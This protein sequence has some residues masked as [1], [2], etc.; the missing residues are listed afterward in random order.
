MPEGRRPATGGSRARRP[1]GPVPPAD[2]ATGVPSAIK[3]GV[4][5][6]IRDAAGRL[7]LEQRSDCGQWGLPGGRVEPGESVRDAALREVQEETGLVVEITRLVGVYSDPAAGRI[8]AYPEK[9]VH[10]IDILLEGRAVGG[11]LRRSAESL[12]VAFFDVAALPADLVPSSHG[13]LHDLL[14]VPSG[15]PRVD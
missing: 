9:T 5:V 2:A 11:R 1:G 12:A 14:R 15:P 4:A 10:S 8:L 6:A 3:L 7:L 13:P